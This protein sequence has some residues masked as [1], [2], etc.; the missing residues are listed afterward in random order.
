MQNNYAISQELTYVK[1]FG[2]N[3][4]DQMSF[5]CNL[6]LN[7]ANT[8]FINIFDDIKKFTAY[9]YIK[10]QLLLREAAL[11]R[12]IPATRNVKINNH[13]SNPYELYEL[14]K[15]EILL[16]QYLAKN[17]TAKEIAKTLNLSFRTVEHHT[18]RI[19][20]KLNVSTKRELFEVLDELG[21]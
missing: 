9:F 12:I 1:K 14:S 8:F 10:A 3:Y 6:P 16:C 21:L 13:Y 5:Y 11:Y 18:D 15:K 19:K 4:V 17:L 2:N 20:N 7:E